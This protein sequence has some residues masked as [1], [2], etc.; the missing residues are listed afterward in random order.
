VLRIGIVQRIDGDD[1]ARAVRHQPGGFESRR[2]AHR[3]SNENDLVEAEMLDN[4][5][6]IATEGQQRPSLAV[7][8]REPMTGEVDREDP[9]G[10]AELLDLR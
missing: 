10:L 8:P 6:D 9:V 7:H 2:P 1:S 4:C 5:L 3:V